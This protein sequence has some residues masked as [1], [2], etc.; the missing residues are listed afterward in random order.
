MSPQDQDRLA[1]IRQKSLTWSALQDTSSWEAPFL[2]RL[3]DE[4]TRE[5]DALRRRLD[6]VE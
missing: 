2:L 3:L 4:K 6:L 5:L 1:D